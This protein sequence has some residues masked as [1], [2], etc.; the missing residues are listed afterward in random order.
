MIKLDDL[1]DTDK[2]TV[3]ALKRIFPNARGIEKVYL[4]EVNKAR[5][6]WPEL[7]YK[8]TV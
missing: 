2:A 3:E 1:S 5:G 7:Q 6:L 4:N 8:D